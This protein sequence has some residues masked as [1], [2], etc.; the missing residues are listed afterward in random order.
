MVA[1]L[2]LTI[3]PLELLRYADMGEAAELSSLSQETLEREYGDWIKSLSKRRKGMRVL[4]A[5]LA[6]DLARTA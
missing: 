2:L 6:G 5:L 3:S 1:Q 4:H